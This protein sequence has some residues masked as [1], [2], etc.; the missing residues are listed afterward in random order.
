[1]HYSQTTYW[2]NLVHAI[3]GEK[4]RWPRDCNINI[5]RFSRRVGRLTKYRGRAQYGKNHERISPVIR[6]DAAAQQTAKGEGT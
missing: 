2:Q 4:R 6:L 3:A 1:M 5:D